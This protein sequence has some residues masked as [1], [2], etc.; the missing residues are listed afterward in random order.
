[1][2]YIWLCQPYFAPMWRGVLK[3]NPFER[4][5]DYGYLAAQMSS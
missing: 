1:M 5:T 4:P 3:G 2:A